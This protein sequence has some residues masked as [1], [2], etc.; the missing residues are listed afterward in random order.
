MRFAPVAVLRVEDDPLVR[1]DDVDEVQPDPELL[2]DPE[3]IVARVRAAAV[4]APADRVGVAFDAEP[5]EEVD[6]FDVD[7]L[8]EDGPCREHRIE[9]ARNEG[10]RLAARPRH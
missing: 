4:R 3:R 1:L 7:P 9:S 10:D 8:F 2:G 5:G 6:A